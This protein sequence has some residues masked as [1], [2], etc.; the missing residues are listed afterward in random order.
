MLINVRGTSGAGKTTVVRALMALCPHKPI[1]G[2][3]G[4][5]R[6]EAYALM[7]PYPVYVLGPYLTPCGGCDC[8]QPFAL[9]PKLIERHAQRGHVVFEG[10]LLSTFFGEIGRLLMETYADSRVMFLDTPLDVCIKRVEAR[11]AAAGNPK[12]F[13]PK[14][15]I[16]KYNTIARL[17]PKFGPRAM[18]ISDGDAVATIIRLFAQ[19]S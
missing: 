14:L 3:L 7:L 11:R 13:D 10:L 16:E 2:V 1:Y 9:I 15:L 17:R 6:P 5:R 8:V 19:H 18:V 12:P 4:P